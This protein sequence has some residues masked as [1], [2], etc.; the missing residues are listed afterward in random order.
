MLLEL[1]VMNIVGGLANV[2]KAA[3]LVSQFILSLSWL[4]YCLFRDEKQT[5]KEKEESIQ[6]WK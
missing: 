4:E 5:Q 3:T 2:T 6:G 1:Q